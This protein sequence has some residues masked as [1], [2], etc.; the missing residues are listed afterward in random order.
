MIRNNPRIILNKIRWD[1]KF[2]IKKIIITYLHRGA[3]QN[4]KIIPGKDIKSIQKSFIETE[5]SMIPYHRI[6]LIKYDDKIIFNR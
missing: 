1:N 6:Q 2:D 4:K 3:Y 5:N